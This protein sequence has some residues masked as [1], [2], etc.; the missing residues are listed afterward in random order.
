M[1][2]QEKPRRIVVGRRVYVEGSEEHTRYL[3]SQKKPEAKIVEP[4]K[5]NRVGPGKDSGRS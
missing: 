4:E 1:S 5:S 2:S 3:E